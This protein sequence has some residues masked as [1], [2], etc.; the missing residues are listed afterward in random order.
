[1]DPP[2][3]GVSPRPPPLSAPTLGHGVTP[4]L[5]RPSS[6]AEPQTNL[7]TIPGGQ[8]VH[9]C[10][11][12]SS[13]PPAW[14]CCSS[15]RSHPHPHQPPLQ[16]PKRSATL[17]PSCLLP[18]NPTSASQC[19]QK[20]AALAH[21]ARKGGQQLPGSASNDVWGVGGGRSGDIGRLLGAAGCCCL[22]LLLLLIHLPFSKIAPINKAL[23][24][25]RFHRG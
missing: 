6:S 23:A 4:R 15:S 14:L 17:P 10:S 2:N 1:M 5:G 21:V 22:L 24:Q 12:F 7:R 18:S 8:R 20:A 3:L 9:L 13:V 25:N 11:P 16:N 19:Q